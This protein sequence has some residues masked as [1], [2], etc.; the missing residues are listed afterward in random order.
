MNE[1]RRDRGEKKDEGNNERG[2]TSE[3]WGRMGAGYLALTFFR[4]VSFLSLFQGAF[5]VRGRRGAVGGGGEFGDKVEFRRVLG[6]GDDPQIYSNDCVDG[7]SDGGVVG[8]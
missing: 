7:R 4:G 1:P 3:S 8:V 6:A 2:E 5:E